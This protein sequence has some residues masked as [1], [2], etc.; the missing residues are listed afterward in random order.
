M[1]L[2]GL[3]KGLASGIGSVGQGVARGLAK[4]SE[5]WPELGMQRAAL[6]QQRDQTKER[7]RLEKIRIDH[8]NT[9]AEALA[10]YRGN[11]LALRRMKIHL[12]P[13]T[14]ELATNERL[15]LADMGPNGLG[16]L[17]PALF[18]KR[19]DLIRSYRETILRFTPSEGVNRLV[20]P[21][22]GAFPPPKLLI[23]G[24]PSVTE[25][26]QPPSVTEIEDGL[27]T[28]SDARRRRKIAKEIHTA[29]T[30]VDDGKEGLRVAIDQVEDMIGG[31]ASAEERHAVIDRLTSLIGQP[32][33]TVDP[34]WDLKIDPQTNEVV[35]LNVFM[36]GEMTEAQS[37]VVFKLRNNWRTENTLTKLYGAAVGSH[38]QAWPGYE[39]QS[40]PGDLDLLYQLAKMLA[41]DDSAVREGELDNMS[42]VMGWVQQKLLL[43]ERLFKGDQLTQEARREVWMLIDEV[44][45]ARKLALLEHSTNYAELAKRMGVKPEWVI[46]GWENMDPTGVWNKSTM[47]LVVQLKEG[48]TLELQKELKRRLGVLP[49]QSLN[50]ALKWWMQKMKDRDLRWIKTAI[51]RGEIIQNKAEAALQGS[52]TPDAE[53]QSNDELEGQ[54]TFKNLLGWFDNNG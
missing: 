20:Q 31:F 18:K 8:A 4:S 43:P 35:R 50:E 16:T 3:V 22:R 21:A 40:A 41:P 24:P 37:K 19:K 13:I 46:P 49:E 23:D 39:S 42:A 34:E 51:Y 5:Q 11:D 9:Q 53:V 54:G 38:A 30:W 28:I 2:G 14:A 10:T 36:L 7:F 47:N 26:V 27:K 12:G 44:K 25:A 52:A 32:E 1:A 48:N 33:W 45:R 17:F 15:I 29:R 6:Q